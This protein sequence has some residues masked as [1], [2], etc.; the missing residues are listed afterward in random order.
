VRV[1]I[2]G[3]GV[4]ELPAYGLADA[5]ARVHKELRAALPGAHIEVREVRR[6]DVAP[7]IVETFE[8]AYSVRVSVEAV[9]TET[10]SAAARRAAFSAGRR[11]LAGTRFGKIIWERADLPAS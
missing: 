3:R 4:V 11:A 5:E 1:T 10:G 9:P 8:I 7:R 6:I 2:H